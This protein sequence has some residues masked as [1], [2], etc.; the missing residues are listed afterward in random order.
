[1]AAPQLRLL[2]LLFP[3]AYISRPPWKPCSTTSWK[4]GGRGLWLTKIS[5]CSPPRSTRAAYMSLPLQHVVS[6]E[7]GPEPQC[8]GKP[9]HKEPAR[10]TVQQDGGAKRRPAAPRRDAN[11][12][13]GRA[14]QRGKDTTDN[15]TLLSG[16]TQ[17]RHRN[18]RPAPQEARQRQGNSGNLWQSNTVRRMK[19]P[20]QVHKC[21]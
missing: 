6:K 17:R 9:L 7:G 20:R 4:G 21:W 8:E 11:H 5:H 2:S 14:S 16:R 18:P 1:M 13:N 19:V 15:A 12:E 10:P 3:H